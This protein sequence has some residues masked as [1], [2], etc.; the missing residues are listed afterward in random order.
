MCG[1]LYIPQMLWAS[2]VFSLPDIL[3]LNPPGDIVMT[4][5]ICPP[6]LGGKLRGPFLTI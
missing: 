5:V 3:L 6:A 2:L 4:V 1:V